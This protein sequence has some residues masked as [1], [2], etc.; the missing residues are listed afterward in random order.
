MSNRQATISMHCTSSLTHCIVPDLTFSEMSFL[1]PRRDRSE[2]L[3]KPTHKKK[4]RQ[5]ERVADTEAEI[6]RYFAS[7]RARD[8]DA[9]TVHDERASRMDTSRLPERRHKRRDAEMLTYLDQASVPPVELPE[10]PFLGFGRAGGSLISP[11]RRSDIPVSQPGRPHSIRREVSPSRSASYLTWSKTRSTSH[12]SSLQRDNESIPLVTPRRPLNAGELTGKGNAGQTTASGVPVL[13]NNNVMD[14]SAVR[15]IK[16]NNGRRMDVLE[17]THGGFSNGPQEP[18]LQLPSSA[19][20]SKQQQAQNIGPQPVEEINIQQPTQSAVVNEIDHQKTHTDPPLTESNGEKFERPEDLVNATLK[21]LLEKYG[22]SV[23]VSPSAIDTANGRPEPSDI[24]TNR[25]DQCPS[26]HP[27]PNPAN[28]VGDEALGEGSGQVQVQESLNSPRPFSKRT[29]HSETWS[30][31]KP[32]QVRDPSIE[33]IKVPFN[34]RGAPH[35]AQLRI[36]PTSSLHPFMRYRADAKSAWYG[37]DAIYE[38]QSMPE[39]TQLNVYGSRIQDDPLF[40]AVTIDHLRTIPGHSQ[41]NKYGP[42]FGEMYNNYGIDNAHDSN[43]YG[44]HFDAKSHQ[45]QLQIEGTRNQPSTESSSYGRSTEPLDERS[46]HAADEYL[47]EEGHPSFAYY[48]LSGLDR[49]APSTN[50]FATSHHAAP[51][52]TVADAG[53]RRYLSFQRRI[54]R[55]ELPRALSSRSRT[56]GSGHGSLQQNLAAVAGQMDNAVLE[57]FWKPHRLY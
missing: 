17:T 5:K 10:T 36:S 12:R 19:R 48:N 27:I 57:G 30:I 49:I 55:D 50:A 22:A 25:K 42:D 24:S 31:D 4:G 51:Q 28:A 13:F 15:E 6:S 23:Q 44:V 14:S 38:Q 29:A 35:N 47:P 56:Q 32:C 37:Y 39:E 21:L 52:S 54:Q 20:D 7:T 46:L 18:D 33:A 11:V 53:N 16:S 1:N 26:A 2:D 34:T 43:A 45:T 40:D 9:T 8:V 3:P 41:E